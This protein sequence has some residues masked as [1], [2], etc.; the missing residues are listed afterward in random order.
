MPR[1]PI[2]LVARRHHHHHS[3]SRSSRTVSSGNINVSDQQSL[4]TSP[5]STKETGDHLVSP[6]SSGHSATSTSSAQ[7]AST[8]RLVGHPYSRAKTP[9]NANVVNANGWTSGLGISPVSPPPRPR[10]ASREGPPQRPPSV[11]RRLS[12]KDASSTNSNPMPALYQIHDIVNATSTTGS[13]DSLAD[14]PM[15]ASPPSSTAFASAPSMMD[16]ERT[17]TKRN[18]RAHI[19]VMQSP[20]SSRSRSHG[21]NDQEP[22]STPTIGATSPR[23]DD[24]GLTLSP[25]SPTHQRV[26]ATA[27]ASAQLPLAFP[28]P[29][30]PDTV[31]VYQDSNKKEAAKRMDA[32]VA[33]ASVAP[34]PSL[35]ESHSRSPTASPSPC[36]SPSFGTFLAIDPPKHA[37]DPREQVRKTG[38]P[39]M[40][41]S[42]IPRKLTRNPF[43]RTLSVHAARD[44]SNGSHS[45]AG[46]MTLHA[47]LALAM[48]HSGKRGHLVVQ[49]MEAQASQQGQDA[50][51]EMGSIDRLSPSL[52]AGKC[53]TT[54]H[55]PTLVS[56]NSSASSGSR[57]DIED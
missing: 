14:E 29:T 2:A 3:R 21:E 19:D 24:H 41:T 1:R 55:R 28:S 53:S 7:G 47:R 45:S 12:A 33:S 25:T 20:L 26:T 52:A 50:D 10:A 4:P 23:P 42:P 56:I 34:S 32:I 39:P 11:H 9:S 5:D 54:L 48:A 57:M 31:A 18:S 51:E 36:P 35:S 30:E 6:S 46:G 44:G 38:L 8:V 16:V 49:A 15:L 17:P 13:N 37:E 22:R 43:E 27:S 40:P